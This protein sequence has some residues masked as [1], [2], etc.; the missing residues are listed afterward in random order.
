MNKHIFAE[1]SE[2]KREAMTPDERINDCN[3]VLLELYLDRLNNLNFDPK[4]PIY[5]FEEQMENLSL[6]FNCIMKMH[7]NKTSNGL[8]DLEVLSLLEQVRA[9][10]LSDSTIIYKE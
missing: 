5:T 3:H 8:N 7:Q 10:L 6:A 2:E 4:S 1:E 9:H